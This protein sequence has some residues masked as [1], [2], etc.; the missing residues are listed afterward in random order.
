M[1]AN[2]Q[3][4]S[5]KV[6]ETNLAHGMFSRDDTVLVAVSGGPDSVCLLDALVSLG[7][8]VEVAHLDHRTRAGDSRLDAEFVRDM[9]QRLGLPFHLESRPVED[10]A[11]GSGQSFEA[12][13]RHVRYEFLRRTA[14]ARNCHVVATGHNADDVAETVL[15]RLVRGASPS[16]L[17]GIP[18]VGEYNGARIIRP[19]IECRRSHILDYLKERNIP[20]RTDSTNTDTRYLRNRVRHEL[21]P[22][23]ETYNSNVRD[24]LL[25]LAD[26]QR[27]DAAFLDA[28]AAKAYAHC[29]QDDHAIKRDRFRD[30]HPALQSR[31]VLVL[32]WKQC[33]DC[34]SERVAAA[35]DFVC[36]GGT[37]LR[38]DV[39]QG[40]SL[41]N[42]RDET[43]LVTGTVE[44][45]DDEIALAV[46]GTTDAFGRRFVVCL[47]PVY[48]GTEGGKGAS[49]REYCSP[50]RQLFDADAAGDHLVVRCWRPGDAFSPLGMSG[51]KKVGDYFTD[52]GVP[53]WE[54]AQTPLLV[55]DKGI[56]WVV[57][58]AVSKVAAV[59]PQTKRFLEVTVESIT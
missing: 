22:L 27:Q 55:G 20:F 10:E 14:Q 29:V 16:G 19:L 12:Y 52:V 39:G 47:P 41:V 45:S 40:V 26:L 46:P 8:S 32:A 7:C 11:R 53:V 36:N 13:A 3:S 1:C 48:G 30:L 5:A 44:M 24:A 35:M 4:L 38:F 57:G 58:H 34:P 31:V 50:T 59:T 6:S 51:S 56:L 43:S 23:L 28:H 18:P 42:G 49:L 33:V 9:A 25:R 37:G 15:M 17:A 54:R 2:T 21:L